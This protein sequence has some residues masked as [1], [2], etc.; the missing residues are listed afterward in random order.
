VRRRGPAW[1][2]L[3]GTGT[4]LCWVLTC[5]RWFD[6]GALWRPAW[7]TGVPSWV[8]GLLAAVLGTSWVWQ[9]RTALL[10]PGAHGDHGGV[11]FGMMAF[12]FRLPLAWWGAAGYVTPDGSL[13][14]IVALRLREGVSRLVFVPHV[15][16]SGSLKSHLAAAL[17]LVVEM[18]RAFALVSILFY[19]LFVAAVYRL[20]RLARLDP[21]SAAAAALYAVFTPAFVTRYSLS[22]DGNYVEVLAL[23][24]WALV[25]LAR[26][27]R[28]RRD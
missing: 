2:T 27:G 14:G 4:A 12:F 13:S 19:A 8:P 23:G 22:N 16:Y 24:A 1:A 7:L 28:V 21:H 10:D 25:L 11:F 26:A 3:A 17:S 15:P 18:P 9:R 20:A 5:L 6:D